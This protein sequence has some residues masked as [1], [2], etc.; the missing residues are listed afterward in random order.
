MSRRQCLIVM[1]GT[2]LVIYVYCGHCSGGLIA[3]GDSENK[4]KEEMEMTNNE[5]EIPM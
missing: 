3:N 5:N 2:C 1:I 4:T